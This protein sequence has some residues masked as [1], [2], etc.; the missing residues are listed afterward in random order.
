MR[1]V[2][3]EKTKELKEKDFPQPEPQRL[4]M[5]YNSKG[6]L[7]KIREVDI[8]RMDLGKVVKEILFDPWD[9]RS[10]EWVYN[11]PLRMRTVGDTFYAPTLDE[12]LR[13]LPNDYREKYISNISNETDVDEY[14]QAWIDWQEKYK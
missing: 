2:S 5:W 11:Q 8:I 4:Q 14:A 6:T 3:F 9:K 7:L 10:D 13:L 12:L 1:V